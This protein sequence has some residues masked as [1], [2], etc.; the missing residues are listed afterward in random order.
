LIE[1]GKLNMA[2]VRGIEKMLESME[3]KQ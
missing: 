1:T 2:D 3:E